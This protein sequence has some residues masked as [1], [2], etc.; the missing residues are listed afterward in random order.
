MTGFATRT[1]SLQLPLGLKNVLRRWLWPLLPGW[2][3]EGRR[4]VQKPH[5]QALLGRA[6]AQS[7]ESQVFV[8]YNAGAG[9]CGYS[10]LLLGLSGVELA[11]ESDFGWNHGRPTRTDPRQVFFAASLTD[12]P[13]V[14]RRFD[15]VL[16]TEVLE[17]VAED[18]QGLDELARI[19][20]PGGWLLITVPTPPA[21]PDPNHVR[22]GYRLPQLSAMLTERGFEVVDSRFCMYFFFRLVLKF[23][24]RLPW[25]PRIL[26]H[27]L[28]HLDR[29]FP[30]GPPMDLMIL[31]RKGNGIE[32]HA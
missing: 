6:V 19:L 30:I 9:E 2:P 8:T 23:W 3:D 7:P 10:P 29:L 28:S 15:L 24:P 12:I 17:H 20:K 22:E 11:V 26:I 21:L 27:L 4:I 13:I 16:C 1:A 25:R 32:K 31:A 18:D 5:L 14:A